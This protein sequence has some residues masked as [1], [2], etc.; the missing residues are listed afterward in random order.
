MPLDVDVVAT[1]AAGVAGAA[2]SM[3]FIKG[4]WAERFAMCAS[5]AV[6]S[7]YGAPWMA[8]KT[9]LPDGLSGFLLGLFGMA[10]C[11]KAWEGIQATPVADVWRSAVDALRKRLGV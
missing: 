2:A 9:G 8:A 4:T 11:A 3:V 7:L 5:G 1:K 6:L 10:I